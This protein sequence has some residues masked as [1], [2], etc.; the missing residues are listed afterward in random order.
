MSTV[1]PSQAHLSRSV[2]NSSVVKVMVYSSGAAR[3]RREE[4]M[5]V[6]NIMNIDVGTLLCGGAVT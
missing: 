6:N 5:D 1:S 2:I 4:P 3:R